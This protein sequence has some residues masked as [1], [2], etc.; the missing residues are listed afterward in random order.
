MRHPRI[1]PKQQLFGGALRSSWQTSNIF[2]FGSRII[3]LLLSSCAHGRI[4]GLKT[5]KD[6]SS[7]ILASTPVTTSADG[8]VYVLRHPGSN[9]SA[10]LWYDSGTPRTQ[11]GCSAP[12]DHVALVPAVTGSL[13][14]HSMDAEEASQESQRRSEHGRYLASNQAAGEGSHDK[15]DQP[16]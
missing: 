13:A 10:R 5:D 3:F 6:M 7:G 4:S 12:A 15:Q 16:G 9:K 14:V 8:T 1:A 11:S 2:H